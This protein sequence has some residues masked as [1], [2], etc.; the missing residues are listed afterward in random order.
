[1]KYCKKCG[2]LYSDL[3]SACPKCGGSEAPEP[4]PAKE[5]PKRVKVRQWIA[6]CVGIPAFVGVMYL[7]IWC[8][9][10]LSGR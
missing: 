4:E 5:A 6:L 7:V 8:L 10:T 1:M 2:V 3:L 9:K